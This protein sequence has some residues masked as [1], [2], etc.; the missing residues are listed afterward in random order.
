MRVGATRSVSIGV[1]NQLRGQRGLKEKVV[2]EGVA[3]VAKDPLRSGEVPAPW[4]VHVKAHLLD[5]CKRCR[6]W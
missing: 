4:G 5:L 3:E 2:V 1:D 6:P